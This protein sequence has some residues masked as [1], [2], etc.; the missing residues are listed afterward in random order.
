[1]GT[2]TN[3][4]SQVSSIINEQQQVSLND[5]EESVATLGITKEKLR[6]ALMEL[7][8]G[9]KIASRSSGGIVTY[10]MLEAS[11]PVKRVVIVEDDKNISK[12]MAISIGKELE[13][14]QVNDGGLAMQTVREFGPQLV[15]LDLMLPNK[16]GLDIC[17]TIKS[18]PQLAGTTVI[19]VSAMDPTSNRFK[20]IKYGADYYIKKPF[21]PAELRNLVTL[22]L[23][24]KGKKFDPLIDLPDEERISKEIERLITG[25][26]KYTIGKLKIE[27][28]S[29][30]A[31]KFG[32]RSGMVL[33]RL[34]S[35]LLQDSITGKGRK[36]FLGFLN[37]DE[38][39]VAGIKDNVKE[40]VSSVKSEF[41]AVLPF[42]L[43]DQGY[44]YIDL[45]LDMLF[46]S[47]EVPK[48]ELK[49]T[50]LQMGDIMKR[51]EEILKTK[52]ISKGGGVGSYTYDELQ[53]MFGEEG[54]LDVHITRESGGNVKLHISKKNED[55]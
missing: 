55:E 48:P 10:Y 25:D 54:D 39:V 33:L 35:Q 26:E 30:Y 2:E 3:P 34:V 50:E 15:I 6:L 1:M 12:L 19:I 11:S 23:K 40:L 24:K 41:T 45:N 42:I 4:L 51:R 31:K 52:K 20:G 38:F 8:A 43:Q 28:L 32:S 17:Q 22:F 36:E 49:Y 29:A 13:I 44:K 9:K 18:D 5:L 16:D 14:K 53:K 7:E 46:D 21:D 37:S 27:N 47:K